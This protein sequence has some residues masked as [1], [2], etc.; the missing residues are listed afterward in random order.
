MS[1]GCRTASDNQADADAVATPGEATRGGDRTASGN[2]EGGGGLE[3]PGGRIR[4]GELDAVV[5][6]SGPP[7]L[8]LHGNSEDSSVFERMLPF[9]N[10]FTTIAVDSRG[11]GGTPVGGKP[12]TIA[13]L[14]IDCCHA[15]HD[16]RRRFGYP[17]RFGLIGFSDGANIGLELAIHRPDLLAAQVLMGGNTSQRAL[18]PVTNAIIMA[19]YWLARLAGTFLAAARR[20]AAVWGL[21]IGQ[22]NH[23]RAQLESVRVP[24]LIMVGARDIVPRRES[25]RVAQLIPGAEWVEI[26]GHGHYLPMRAAALA[27]QLSAE[28]LARYLQ[29]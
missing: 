18:K 20:R 25:Q 17:G 11:H 5:R 23:S 15:L 1:G 7:V 22:P 19:G 14:G 3:T 13:Q 6:G 26:A 24:T 12:M 27:G 29:S 4:L 21:M 2:Q 8:L 9:L 28:F 16:Y 10:A